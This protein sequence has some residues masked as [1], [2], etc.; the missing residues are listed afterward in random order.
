MSDINTVCIS[1]R[2]GEDPK[3]KYFES[4][5]L[6]ADLSVGVNKYS[7]KQEKEVVT[8]HKVTAWGNKA[9]Y[10]SDV[11]KSG[12]F[13]VIQGTLEKDTYQDEA[14]NNRAS[15]YVLVDEIKIQNKKEQ[16]EG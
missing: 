10:I 15:V 3:L 1:G 4:G 16:A 11:A 9:K 5:A 7:A 12:A 14:G 6:K 2:L 13:V 8:W